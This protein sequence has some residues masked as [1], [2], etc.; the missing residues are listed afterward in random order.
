MLYNIQP[1]YKDH[2]CT[3]KIITQSPNM[4]G[5]VIY[6]HGGLYITGLIVNFWKKIQMSLFKAISN[7]S[8][9][10]P[11]SANIKEVQLCTR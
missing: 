8:N 5:G 6:M 2:L 3:N 1:V 9:K 7:S 10:N 4:H 11:S